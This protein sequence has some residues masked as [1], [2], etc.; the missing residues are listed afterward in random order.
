[1]FVEVP[2]DLVLDLQATGSIRRVVESG[3]MDAVGGVKMVLEKLGGI[4][5]GSPSPAPRNFQH[6]GTSM[7]T[8]PIPAPAPVG[9]GGPKQDARAPS[10]AASSEQGQCCRKL[11]GARRR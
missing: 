6:T 11:S 3:S 5:N 9:Q 4:K 8:S 7:N 2:K 10:A 1:M